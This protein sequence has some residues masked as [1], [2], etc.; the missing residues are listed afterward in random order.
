MHGWKQKVAKKEIVLERKEDEL[1]VFIHGYERERQLIVL[2][3]GGIIFWQKR[4]LYILLM[5][6]FS[7]FLMK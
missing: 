6:L 2:I 4:M 3:L 5:T 7:K 1:I